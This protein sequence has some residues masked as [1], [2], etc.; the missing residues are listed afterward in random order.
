[1]GAKFF[2]PLQAGFAKLSKLISINILSHD[3]LATSF[4]LEKIFLILLDFLHSWRDD[5]LHLMEPSKTCCTIL[6]LGRG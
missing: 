6:S 1:M 2:N 5:H 3:R 4:L